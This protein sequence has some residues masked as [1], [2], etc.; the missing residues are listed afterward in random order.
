[1]SNLS[2]RQFP[3]PNPFLWLADRVSSAVAGSRSRRQAQTIAAAHIG[4]AQAHYEGARQERQQMQEHEKALQEQRFQ[5]ETGMISH[6]HK[7]AQAGTPISM[8]RSSE[9]VQAS[10]TK[11]TPA[12]RQPKAEAPAAPA[13]PA[14]APAAKPAPK[15]WQQKSNERE[16]AKIN[17]QKAAAAAKYKK[18]S[19]KK[20]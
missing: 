11:R 8:S 4:M 15:T 7:G 17:K 2:P 9:G 6:I 3:D 1:M 14:S 10:Y 12:T 16:Q 13:A 18:A 19:P 5:H 20:K